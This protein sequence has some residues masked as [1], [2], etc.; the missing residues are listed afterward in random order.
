MA[1]KIRLIR[2]IHPVLDAVWKEAMIE[3]F[4]EFPISF[5][6]TRSSILTPANLILQDEQGGNV[7]LFGQQLA[8]RRRCRQGAHIDRSQTFWSASSRY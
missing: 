7:W 5:G 8:R 4:Q 1:P 2:Q 3:G 6:A